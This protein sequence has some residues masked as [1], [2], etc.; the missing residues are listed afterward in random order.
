MYTKR[1]TL[2][3]PVAEPD[4]ARRWRAYHAIRE[5]IART[6]LH[7]GQSLQEHALAEWLGMSRTP[8]REALRQLTAEGLIEQRQPRRLVV[9]ELSAQSVREAY[10]AIEV[11][12]GV[13]SRQAAEIGS[14][15][16]FA[17]ISAALDA[18]RAATE[19]GDF[20]GWI[21]ADNALHAAV[22][23]ASGNHR[24][25]EILDSLFRTIERVRHMHLREGSRVERLRDGCV[26]HVEYVGPIL[27]RQPAEA[28]SQAR[29]LFANAREQ[30]LSL[31]DRW[32]VPLRRVF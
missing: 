9:A 20:D 7:A 23:A 5:A 1:R 3:R 21:V 2:K 30:T 29:L 24:I 17:A 18:M 14:P 15:D 13:L 19:A 10:L 4:L 27:A 31:L 28:E 22:H 11:L 6:E 8:V 26:E 16:G 25:T 12:E 32:V